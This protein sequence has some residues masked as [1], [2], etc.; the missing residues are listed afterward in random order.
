MNYVSSNNTDC[1]AVSAWTIFK[2]I[3][4][5]LFWGLFT[6][7]FSLGNCLSRR[8]LSLSLLSL[9]LSLYRPFLILSVAS[10]VRTSSL[11]NQAFLN[12]YKN[13]HHWRTVSSIAG[14]VRTDDQ[15]NADE[16][17]NSLIRISTREAY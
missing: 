1:K 3:Y 13:C 12:I 10:T 16:E 6:L 9:S 11:V 15:T 17:T 7:T 4:L 14:R 5:T 2:Y 8:L